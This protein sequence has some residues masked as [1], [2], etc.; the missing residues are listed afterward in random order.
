M[1]GN[2][3]AANSELNIDSGFAAI[4]LR[5]P[6]H[7]SCVINT[8]GRSIVACDDAS[9]YRSEDSW[10]RNQETTIFRTPLGTLSGVS[11][12]ASAAHRLNPTVQDGVYRG[13]GTGEILP[14]AEQLPSS[15][16]LASSTSRA[17][18]SWTVNINGVASLDLGIS[19]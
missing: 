18:G 11:Q 14:P 17:G 4:R 9:F 8:G 16:W 12:K 19:S 13:N 3:S 1:L 5:L 10:C 6:P 15:L 7:V 2:P